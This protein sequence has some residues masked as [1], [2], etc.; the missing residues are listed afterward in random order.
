VDEQFGVVNWEESCPSARVLSRIDDGVLV[1]HGS[2]C[3]GTE[4]DPWI[5][6]AGVE[7]VVGVA[8]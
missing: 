2:H 6:C 4:A 3:S 5:W 1:D 7:H 8:G